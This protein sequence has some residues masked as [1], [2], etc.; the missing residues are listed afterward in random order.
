MALQTHTPP[1][2]G[3]RRYRR[4][5]KLPIIGANVGGRVTLSGED[6]DVCILGTLAAFG[7][8][9]MPSY[10]TTF[11]PANTMAAGGNA[12]GPLASTAATG[13]T[14]NGVTTGPTPS[15]ASI[16]FG[17]TPPAAATVNGVITGPTSST[18]MTMNTGITIPIASNVNGVIT[19]TTASTTSIPLTINGT[20]TGNGVITGS[21]SSTT[22][23]SP[24]GNTFPIASNVNGVITG[25]TTSTTT[26]PL[27]MNGTVTGNIIFTAL[28]VFT[29]NTVIA[30]TAYGVNTV[31]GANTTHGAH[32][33]N[34]ARNTNRFN[35]IPFS[36][37]TGSNHGLP[38]E[39]T[40][41]LICFK[42]CKG[43]FKVI[44][45]LT[46]N[47]FNQLAVMSLNSQMREALDIPPTRFITF[48]F[49]IVE[50]TCIFDPIE[51]TLTL[52]IFWIDNHD[53]K[54]IIKASTAVQP[55][56]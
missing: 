43:V 42:E 15:T 36:I 41:L 22:Y 33:A 30:N 54:F 14:V 26:I 45:D 34:G 19:G 50:G 4:V 7:P 13:S 8:S 18:A 44:R 3:L 25:P 29:T 21:T 27:T 53:V 38:Y 9:G 17:N 56:W 24:T 20:V 48:P 47:T 52:D 1:Y 46:D 40:D 12:V 2:I 31:H 6:N 37:S 39:L 28:I 51:E 10:T 32:T 16:P 23:G 55:L 5:A 49:A 35:F 11:G